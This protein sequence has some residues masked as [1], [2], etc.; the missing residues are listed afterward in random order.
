MSPVGRHSE[1]ST[2]G[3]DRARLL[4]RRR[5]DPESLGLDLGAFP[6]RPHG[7][8]VADAPFSGHAGFPDIV[9][10]RG[11]RLVLCEL[12]TATGRLRPEQRVWLDELDKTPAEVYLWRPK[13]WD[14]LV[15]TLR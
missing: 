10:T 13:H 15:E 12:K 14:E 6:T 7:A 3:R 9:A 4:Y 2:D 1:R 8:R 5:G 11:A